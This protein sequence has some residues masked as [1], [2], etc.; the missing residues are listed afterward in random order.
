[1][2]TKYLHIV[3]IILLSFVAKA[4]DLTPPDT[5]IIDSV[6]VQWLAPSNP[7]GDVLIAWQK[8]DSADVRS[9]YIKYLNEVLGTYQFLDSVDANTTVYIDSK[10]VTDPHYP[11]TY[12]IQAVD[13]SNNT[14]NH[15]VS[16][17]TVRV[18]PWQKNQDCITKVE[19]TWNAYEGWP[20]GI[21]Y[22]D[23]YSV[24]GGITT[25][26]GQ[27]NASTFVHLYPVNESGT[28]FM[29][30]A[31]VTSING[32]TSTSNKIPFTP[33]IDT[34]PTFIE[35]EYVTVDNKQ[36]RMKFHLD[37]LADI[38]NYELM[39]SVDS[40][41]N[42]Q[43]IMK[44]KD[45]T[46]SYIDATDA[47]V[48]VDLH[49]YYYKLNVYNDCDDLLDSSR[50]ISTVLLKGE[51]EIKEHYQE[52][53]WSNYYNENSFEKDYYL[54]RYSTSELDKIV[55]SSS[56]N[57]Y[58]KDDLREQDFR[59]FVGD[60]CYYIDVSADYLGP[61]SIR[62]NTVCLSQPPSVVMPNAFAPFGSMGN[63]V[64]KPSFAFISPDNYSFSVYDRWGMKI[65]ETKDY[66]EG[67]TGKKDG[68]T[69]NNGIYSYYLEYYSSDG[70]EFV[71]AGFFNLIN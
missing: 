23:L 17:R 46:E 54:H 20:E 9:Y 70:K 47:N 32:R 41:S 57:Y 16:H 11:Q 4:Q 36:T 35:A 58:Y 39:R 60:F 63:R 67:W 68:F 43:S 65:F 34:K 6:T 25:H 38:N 69:Y 12:V 44:F 71:E 50:A 29:Y 52:L 49:R 28:N 1:M 56:S 22:Y 19:L 8:S 37:L 45:Y 42:F 59:S 51:A 31:R 33:D 18:F 61:E 66:K 13:S 21:A 62:S 55:F 40:L 64:F 2:K 15:S 26:I 7:N 5:P 24:E 30:Y 10:S 14:S 27:F 3:L 53:V 48:E